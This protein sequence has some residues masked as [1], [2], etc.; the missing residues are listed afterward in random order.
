MIQTAG[1]N[2]D[3]LES[4]TIKMNVRLPFLND[5]TFS[6]SDKRLGEPNN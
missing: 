3:N 4:I 6:E 1:P 2:V 5:N